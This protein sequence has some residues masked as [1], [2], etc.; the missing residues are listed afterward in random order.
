MENGLITI[1]LTK[2]RIL[3]ETLPLLAAAGIKPA[4]DIDKSRKLQFETNRDN[5]RLLV[6]RGV[7][8]LTYIRNGVADI[9][10]VGKDMLLEEGG[11]ELYELVDLHIARCRLMTARPE[12]VVTQA[13]SGRRKVATKYVNL[14]RAW[15][16]ERGLQA[17]IIKLYGGMELAPVMG[18]AEEI[19]DIVD[20]GKTLHANGLVE[21]DLIADISSRLVANKASMKVKHQSLQGLADA[22]QEAVG[23]IDQ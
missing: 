7:D 13:K 15:Y 2:G 12:G 20:T 1:A 17:D 19:V 6:L 16:S 10:V 5:V 21:C 8:A 23:K 4:E 3:K 18:L 22:I 14:A 9:G 11:D